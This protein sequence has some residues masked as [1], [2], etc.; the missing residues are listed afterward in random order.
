MSFEGYNVVEKDGRA[1]RRRFSSPL[2]VRAVYQKLK[3]DDLKEAERRAK[4]LKMYAGNLPYDPEKLR[5]A[6][7]KNVANIN[8]HGLKS[9]IDNRADVILRL[10]SDTANV[11]EFRPMRREIAGPAAEHIARVVAEEFSYTLR[12][13]GKFIPA[14]AMMNKEADLYGLGPVTWPTSLD[15]NPVALE[16]TQV[17]FIGNAPVH[18]SEHELI[19]YESVLPASYL[20]SIMDNPDLAKA[21]GWNVQIAKEWAVRVF[22][23]GNETADEPGTSPGTSVLET[24]ISLIRRNLFEEEHQ[25]DELK[26]IHVFVKEM[27]YPRG[28]THLIIPA[29]AP[30]DKEDAFLFEKQ[31]AYKTLDECFMWFPYSINERYAK[32]VRG[33]GSSLYAVEAASNRL[34]C[35]FL[36]AAFRSTT[37]MFTQAPGG[38]QQSVTLNEQGPFTF[39]PKELTPIQSNVRPDLSATVSA[40]SYVDQIGVASVEGTDKA[41]IATTGP[42]MFNQQGNA[43]TK[44]EIELQQKLRSHKDEALFTQRA[45]VVD[46]LVRQSF[47]RF[48]RL[49]A[50][51][52]TEEGKLLAADYPEV[53]EF[54]ERCAKRNVSLEE[55]IAIPSDYTIVTCRDLVLGSE[56]KVG[57]LSEILGGPA[58]GILDETGRKNA[59]RD[60]VQLRLGIA[61]ADRYIPE[62]SRDQAPNDQSSFAT[63]ENALL[64]LGQE[65]VVGDDQ[66]HWSHIPTHARVIQDIVETVGAPADNDPTHQVNPDMAAQQIENPKQLLAV[67]VAASKHIQDHL[68]IGKMQHGM[69]GRAKQVEKML[70]DLRPTIKSLN[71]AV[72]TQ[73]RVEEAQREKAQ[74]EQEDLVRR[75]N[76]NEVLKAKVEA[77]RK[78]QIDKYRAD[79][80]HDV[81][82]RRL[83]LDRE[84]AGAK[85]GLAAE[86]AEADRARRDAETAARI[87]RED[88][89]R[90]AKTNAASAVRRFDAVQDATG[91]GRTT[92]GDVIGEQRVADT[93]AL[94]PV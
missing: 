25:F 90:Q 30:G 8:F 5:Q 86:T 27:A 70:R 94:L 6:G 10:S 40:I 1:A 36:D 83:Q 91:F 11:V 37:I 78:A 71:L 49:V 64:K 54:I 66:L 76:E 51:V 65:V 68:A 48:V 22:A 72:A 67:L 77:D 80:D 16:R 23:Q 35:A 84:L 88:K 75:A 41:P 9:V 19:M 57:V 34:K 14:L 63:V 69:E 85:S 55:I 62:V 56:G 31:N 81:A 28:V 26:V 42:R 15:Y 3:E 52:A 47:I 59:M 82:L 74:R 38:S 7:I 43:Q 18:S 53:V 61:S 2:A 33:L 24:Q 13:V 87:E 50:L 29:S 93:E 73:E 39:V 89:L 20:F 45:Q 32:A 12:D 4:I 46:K 58:A 79:L 21:A 44:A 92:P 60:A 17:K